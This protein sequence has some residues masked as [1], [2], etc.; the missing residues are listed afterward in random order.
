MQQRRYEEWKNRLDGI[1]FS[2]TRLDPTYLPT[3]LPVSNGESIQTRYS[4]SFR[5]NLPFPVVLLSRFNPANSDKRREGTPTLAKPNRFDV[6]QMVRA[7]Q[8]RKFPFRE[9]QL[10]TCE[11]MSVK[12]ERER[13]RKVKNLMPITKRGK[14]RR[15]IIKINRLGRFLLVVQHVHCRVIHIY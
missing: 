2:A 8:S 3:Y 5:T 9:H 6:A 7:S 11:E 15:E 1:L 10:D 12:R 4:S 13:E 14:R